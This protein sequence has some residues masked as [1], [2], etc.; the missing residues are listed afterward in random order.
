MS[1]KINRLLAALAA[2]GLLAACSEQALSVAAQEPGSDTACALDGMV[3]LDFPGPKA[4]IHY[5]EG[6]ADYYCDL[7]ELFTVMLA[8]EHKRRIAGVFVQDMGKTSWDKPS[9]HWIAA[10]DALYVVGSKKLGSMGPTFG[11]FSDAAQAAAF[12]KAEGGKVLPYSQ[13]TVAMLDTGHAAGDM[14]H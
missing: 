9:G 2:A 10:K 11:A 14:R 13:I 6:K 8:P 4:Q 5:A 12:A 3:L 1:F 7:M